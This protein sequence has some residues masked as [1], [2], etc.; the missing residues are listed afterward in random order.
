LIVKPGDMT[1]DEMVAESKGPTLVIPRTWY[2]YPTRYGGR[3]FS[4]SNRATSY[5]VEK[6]EL[7]SVAP[8]AFKMSGDMSLLLNGVEGISKETKVGTTWAATSAYIVPW[9]KT[10]GFKVEKPREN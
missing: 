8:N 5:I 2:T 6:G 7:V 10:T 1:F 4:S 3:Q 9:I